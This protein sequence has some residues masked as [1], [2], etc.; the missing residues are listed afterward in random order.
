MLQ[1]GEVQ[2]ALERMRA[3]EASAE[4]LEALVAGAEGFAALVHEYVFQ[5]PQA[6]LIYATQNDMLAET[7]QAARPNE[8]M[9]L[10]LAPPLPEWPESPGLEDRAK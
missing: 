8:R 5:S 9:L 3:G 2:Q 4:V 1:P 7:M 6:G 10:R